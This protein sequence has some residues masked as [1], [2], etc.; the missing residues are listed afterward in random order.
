MLVSQLQVLLLGFNNKDSMVLASRQ[1]GWL[2]ESNQRP[3][4]NSHTYG[5]LIFEK[6]AKTM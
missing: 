6:E 4:I 2:M 5:H 3:E 1:T